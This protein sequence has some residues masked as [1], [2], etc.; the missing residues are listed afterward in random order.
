PGSGDVTDDG[1]ASL[2][3]VAPAISVAKSVYRTHDG[4]AQCPGGE[5]VQGR[6]GT[7]VT[8]CFVVTNEGDTTLVDVGVS[9][10]ALG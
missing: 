10:P 5:L 4:G 2:D 8:W 9:D 7:E 6:T 1:Q 3:Q